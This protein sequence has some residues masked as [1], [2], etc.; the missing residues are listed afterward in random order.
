MGVVNE[1]IARNGRIS[2]HFTLFHMGEKAMK[3]F[4]VTETI[5][6]YSFV[7]NK[8]PH[9]MPCCLNILRWDSRKAWS[10]AVAHIDNADKSIR[11]ATARGRFL[12]TDPRIVNEILRY[13][14]ESDRQLLANE[15]CYL[16]ESFVVA[17]LQYAYRMTLKN[18]RYGN[19]IHKLKTRKYSMPKDIDMLYENYRCR[20]SNG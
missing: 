7:L 9:C 16:V 3:K 10:D 6:D 11:Y 8:E 15:I 1:I 5:G 20:E 12:V 18:R 19:Y 17:R 14:K 13:E 4:I 2:G